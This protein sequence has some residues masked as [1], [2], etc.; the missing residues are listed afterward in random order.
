MGYTMER[1]EMNPSDFTHL[2]G[3]YYILS[4]LNRKK[5]VSLMTI[6]NHKAID[7]IVQSNAGIKTLDVKAVNKSPVLLGKEPKKL[8]QNPNHYYV[9][10]FLGHQKD[11]YQNTNI[12]PKVFIVPSKVFC[13]FAENYAKRT[14]SKTLGVGISEIEKY[15]DKWKLLE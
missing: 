4:C 12:P 2:A 1:T 14:P 8:F 11:A 9:V 5:I 3:E 13:E 10:V 7:I 6:G 15:Q